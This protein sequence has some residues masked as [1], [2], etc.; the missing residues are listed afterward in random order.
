MPRAGEPAARGQPAHFVLGGRAFGAFVYYACLF[1]E[2]G[3][4][5][6]SEG[7]AAHVSAQSCECHVWKWGF[8]T[9]APRRRG[10]TRL[11]SS[12]LLCWLLL[13]LT[14][15]DSPTLLLPFLI[16]V[17]LGAV[18][19]RSMGSRAFFS[20]PRFSARSPAKSACLSSACCV[21]ALLRHPQPYG[22]CS[23]TVHQRLSKGRDAYLT[24]LS[25]T[26]G[27]TLFVFKGTKPASRGRARQQPGAG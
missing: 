21:C 17:L 25:C 9:H 4:G 24:M 8:D 23:C 14:R 12:A 18:P 20:Q 27:R 10:I 5:R 6:Y 3:E 22:F 11:G 2:H 26:R 16:H 15:P 1:S 19:G 7:G 13:G